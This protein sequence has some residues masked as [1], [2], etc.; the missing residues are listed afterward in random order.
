MGR[1]RDLTDQ[2]GDFIRSHIPIPVQ[3]AMKTSDRPIWQSMLNSVGVTSYEART[4]F[5]RAVQEEK[6]KKYVATPL[7]SERDR[8]KLVSQYGREYREAITNK[9]SKGDI[10]AR[11]KKISERE[12]LRRRFGNDTQYGDNCPD[13]PQ[14]KATIGGGHYPYLEQDNSGR[15][16]TIP[17]GISSED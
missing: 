17:R 9:T 13:S 12:S 8:M 5:D 4:A 14:Y 6:G 2:A 7:K 11:L 3:G 15:E 16:E 1:Y 10:A